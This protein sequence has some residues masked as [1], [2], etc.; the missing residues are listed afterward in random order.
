[1]RTA[2]HFAAE[3]WLSSPG[4]VFTSRRGEHGRAGTAIAFLSPIRTT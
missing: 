2:H 4:L 1:M 3:V